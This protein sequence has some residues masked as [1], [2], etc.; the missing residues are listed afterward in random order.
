MGVFKKQGVYWIDYYVQGQRKRGRIGP[1]KRLAEN[2]LRKREVEIAEG[3]F[4]QRRRPITTTFDELAHAYLP[5]A[6][7]N[8]RSWVRDVRRIKQLGAFFGGKRLTQ[9][10]PAEIERFKTQRLASKD[11]HGR[12]PKPATV[13]RELACLKHMFNVARR[14]LLHLVRGAPGWESSQQYQILRRTQ[15]PR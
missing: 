4:L 9:M 5:Y 10:P 14:G 6:R 11:S 8:K 1:D 3:K 15:H 2:V 7:E 12:H 13:N